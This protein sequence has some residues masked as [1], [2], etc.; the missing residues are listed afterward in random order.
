MS[1][2]GRMTQLKAKNEFCP[3]WTGILTNPVYL[4]RRGIWDA[5]RRHKDV[6]QEEVLDFGSGCRPYLELFA[7]SVKYTTRGNEYT[8]E[9]YY[10]GQ[11]IFVIYEHLVYPGLMEHQDTRKLSRSAQEALRQKVVRECLSVDR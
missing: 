7:D 9:W 11:K 1:I 10:L 4:A 5:L 8:E 2:L 3:D 6:F